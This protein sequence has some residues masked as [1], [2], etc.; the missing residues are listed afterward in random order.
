MHIA[1]RY[2]HFFTHPRKNYFLLF[3]PERA[4]RSACWRRYQN[5][6]GTAVVDK[7]QWLFGESSDGIY[8]EFSGEAIIVV[9]C[10]PN[11]PFFTALGEQFAFTTQR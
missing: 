4:A 7:F 11:A 9:T 10:H 1:N 3:L 5:V 6:R 2:R 8:D